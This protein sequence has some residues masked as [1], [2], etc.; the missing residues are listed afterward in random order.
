MLALPLDN[1]PVAVVLYFVKRPALPRMDLEAG[2]TPT[3]PIFFAAFFAFLTHVLM[4]FLTFFAF[5]AL[6]ATHAPA[7]AG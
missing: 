2:L 4:G 3:C 1:Q 6:F 7:F 5:L